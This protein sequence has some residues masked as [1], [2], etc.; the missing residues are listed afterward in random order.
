MQIADIVLQA[1]TH[2]P[3][4]DSVFPNV[5]IASG[6][7]AFPQTKHEPVD[8]LNYIKKKFLMFVYS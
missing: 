8:F 7:S 6:H 5:N 3:H 2:S 4:P 1:L